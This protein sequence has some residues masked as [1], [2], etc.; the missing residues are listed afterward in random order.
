MWLEY[1]YECIR[2]MK[3]LNL[4]DN[5]DYVLW[6]RAFPEKLRELI[7]IQNYAKDVVQR[8]IHMAVLLLNKDEQIYFLQQ[9]KGDLE[10][11]IIKEN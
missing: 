10:S 6:L 1:H 3:E 7:G 5:P 4:D 11:S 9:I 8:S 2:M